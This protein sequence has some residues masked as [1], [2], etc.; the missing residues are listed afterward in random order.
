MTNYLGAR[1][2][3]R[4]ARQIRVWIGA[5]GILNAL[6]FGVEMDGTTD[7]TAALQ[8]ALDAASQG[9]GYVYLPAGTALIS[10]TLTIGDG[11]M[12][13]GVSSSPQ[14]ENYSMIKAV[15]SGFSGSAVIN[16]GGTMN[17]NSSGLERL[18]IDC[19]G[20]VDY[21][22]FSNSIGSGCVIENCRI[23]DGNLVGIKIDQSGGSGIFSSNYSLRDITIR[24]N[25]NRP[26]YKGIWIIGGGLGQKGING[27]VTSGAN[28]FD[29]GIQLDSYNAAVENIKLANCNVG[30]LIG[31]VAPCRGLAVLGVS[32]GVS[33]V[34]L[35]KIANN[36][37]EAVLIGLNKN[38]G[39]NLINDLQSGRIYTDDYINIYSIGQNYIQPGWGYIKQAYDLWY[40]DNVPASQT[41]VLLAR[42]DHGG[43]DPPNASINRLIFGRGGSI[44][45]I[46]VRL[47]AARSAGTLTVE[48]YINSAATGLQATINTATDNAIINAPIGQYAFSAL[49]RIDLRIT[50][51]SSWAPTTADLRAG[52][53]VVI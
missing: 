42:A 40:Q 22:V 14:L 1:N 15:S 44:T 39:T 53:E 12:L 19:S 16:L 20:T 23:L 26:T 21:G 10:A 52:I 45:Q 51:D 35:I 36:D 13:H 27:V 37:N 8:S 47:T 18:I 32:G 33:V 48:A 31:D 30:I 3:E 4:D 2:F 49:D 25:I 28:Q 34:D 29:I 9:G 50:T 41:A 6:D 38:G 24:Q 7:D 43:T 17:V 46:W 5:P 11:V